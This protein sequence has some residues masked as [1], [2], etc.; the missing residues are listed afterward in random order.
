[1]KAIHEMLDELQGRCVTCARTIFY[2]FFQA[3][4]GIRD[5][6]V[7]GVQTCALPISHGARPRLRRERHDARWSLS[8]S[9][10]DR[11]REDAARVARARPQE[12]DEGAPSHRLPQGEVR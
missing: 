7:T 9:L 4:D 1:M 11:R 12:R 5:R 3:E 8:V 10:R 6:T 2:F